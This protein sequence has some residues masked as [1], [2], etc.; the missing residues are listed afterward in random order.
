MFMT[1]A[2]LWGSYRQWHDH[3][4]GCHGSSIESE[5][6]DGQTLFHLE[7][8]GEFTLLGNLQVMGDAWHSMARSCSRLPPPSI[9]T[10]FAFALCTAAR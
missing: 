8:G 9:N 10:L 5:E 6:E 7:L 2:H 1:I 3:L 4:G